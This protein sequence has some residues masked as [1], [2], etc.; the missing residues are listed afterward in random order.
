MTQKDDKLKDGE[1]KAAITLAHKDFHK[2][3]NTY[4][5][6]KV[7]NHALSEEL[8]QDTFIKTWSYLVKGGE[9]VKMKAFLYHVLNGLIIDEYRKRKASSLDALIENGYEPAFEEESKIADAFDGKK[10]VQLIE[11]LP[12]AYQK[13]MRMRYVQD[14]SLAE[15]A[16]ITGKTK[17]T[18]AVHAHRGLE[19]LKELYFKQ[20]NLN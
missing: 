10:A 17:N 7:N 6:F 5:S 8:V 3:L 19:K 4:A 11:Q 16:V 13:V 14:L 1:Q 2:G 20:E 15:M 9:I 12:K 18:M